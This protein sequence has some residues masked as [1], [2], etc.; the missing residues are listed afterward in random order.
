MLFRS[1]SIARTWDTWVYHHAGTYHLYYC[2]SETGPGDGFGVATSEDG[3]TWVDHGRVVG[4]SDKMVRY[5]GAGSVWKSISSSE[6]EQ[7]ICNY[8]EWRME[9]DD[10]IQRILVA[11]SNDL[12]HW[13][14]VDDAASFRIDERFYQKIKKDAHGPWEWPRWDGLCVI[15][16]PNGGYYGYWTAT[17]RDALGFG[18]G[19]SDDGLHWRALE[20]PQIAWGDP[21]ELYFVEVGGVHEFDGKFY[22]MVGD[23]ADI[24]CGMYTLVTDAPGGPFRPASRNFGLLRN[25]TRMHVYFSRFLDTPNGVLVNH[26]TLAEGK[27]S[28]E[29][30]VVYVAPLKRARIIDDGLY[31]AWWSGNDKLKGTEIA[32]SATDK[33]TVSTRADTGL[34]LEG[35]LALPGS[36]FIGTKGEAGVS[37]AV[38]TDATT[39]I[40]P[41]AQDGVLANCEEEVNREISLGPCP[42]FR[43]LLRHTML[44]FYLED[45]LVQCYTMARPMNGTISCHNAAALKLWSWT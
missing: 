12:V 44:E 6:P 21:P 38:D 27:F 8:S 41:T 40:G 4:P 25:R 15:P 32:I 29:H 18:F 9:D 20:P 5:M 30:F 17:P 33:D 34:I 3:V 45:L 11:R 14:K 2:T 37:I 43:L 19:E 42:R 39:R 16:R 10:A 1:T 23:Y 7:F 36:L 13:H 35:T 31:L 24:N 28:D 22:C 26:H